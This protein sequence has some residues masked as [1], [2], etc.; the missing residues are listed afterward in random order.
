MFRIKLTE[1]VIKLLKKID[2]RSQKQIIN[3]IEEL[4]IEPLKKGKPLKGNLSGFRSLRA[5]GQ[6]YR[7]IYQVRDKDL[8]VVIVA[9]GIRK[10][11]DKQDI[12]NLFKKLVKLEIIEK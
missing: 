4:K 7:I 11:G 8:I 6:R 12:Y 1:T 2:K 3:K 10:D 9:I 5:A